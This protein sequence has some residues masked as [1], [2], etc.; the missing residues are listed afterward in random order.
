MLQPVRIYLSLGS[1]LR[2]RAANIQRAVQDL[3][4]A[5][6]QVLRVSAFYETEPVDVLDQPWFLNCVVEA[7][8]FLSPQE[9]LHALQDVSNRIG[10]PKA[11]AR[12]PRVIDIDILFYGDSVI[13]TPQL[14]I[15]H[16]RMAN[17]KFVLVPLAELATDFIHPT[18]RQSIRELLVTTPDKS[19]VR[20]A[21]QPHR[22]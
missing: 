1:N 20:I 19:A 18:L 2:D 8:T 12:G 3:P 21:A 13:Q 6:A 15:P 9:L 7:Q 5:G 17:R 10:P 14:E 4:A 11:I 16:P 22:S